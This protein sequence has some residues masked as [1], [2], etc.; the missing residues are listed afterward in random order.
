MIRKVSICGSRPLLT[1]EG[2]GEVLVIL[3]IPLQASPWKGADFY[4]HN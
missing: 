2:L 1:K 3:S 4:A